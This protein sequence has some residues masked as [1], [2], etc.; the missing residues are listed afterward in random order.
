LAR[1]NTLRKL[2]NY[3]VEK[4][5]SIENYLIEEAGVGKNTIKIIKERFIVSY[6]PSSKQVKLK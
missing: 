5:G 6:A 3:L 4:Y 2:I 1:E